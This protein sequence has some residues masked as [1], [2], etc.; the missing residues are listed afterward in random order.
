MRVNAS[1]VAN[2]A[3]FFSVGIIAALFMRL[4]QTTWSDLAL[5]RQRIYYEDLFASWFSQRGFNLVG[6][7][8]Y[9]QITITVLQHNS[10]H[11]H[12]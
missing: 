12:D 9:L 6:T 10:K 5:Q 7:V 11:S 1:K 2:F 3:V 4:S 8:L